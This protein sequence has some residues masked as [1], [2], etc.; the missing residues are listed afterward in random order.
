MANLGSINKSFNGG[1]GAG[2]QNPVFKI[3]AVNPTDDLQQPRG[4]PRENPSDNAFSNIEIGHMVSCKK[5]KTI[6]SGKV[7]KLYKNDENDVI[8]IEFM[9][10]SGEKIKIDVSRLY[11]ASDGNI[12]D[13][14]SQVST[15]VSNESVILKFNEFINK[16]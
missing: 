12:P 7:S 2:F 14:M 11:D 9:T 3:S 8:Y 10:S 15:S 5:G 1:K 6:V 4:A 13:D 16:P